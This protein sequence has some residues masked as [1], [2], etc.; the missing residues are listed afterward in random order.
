MRQ[1][2]LTSIVRLLV[3]GGGLVALLR[4][5]VGAVAGL[6]KELHH[7]ALL[8]IGSLRCDNQSGYFSTII[9]L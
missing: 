7:W 5:L 9:K 3:A 1:V 6:V 2:S 8:R 4:R